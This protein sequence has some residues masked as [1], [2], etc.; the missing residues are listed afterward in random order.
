MIYRILLILILFASTT[1]AN[2][3]F[4][5]VKAG[6][7]LS[8]M[9]DEGGDEDLN[10]DFDENYLF[11]PGFH[12][13]FLLEMNYNDFTSFEADLLFS[14]KG[15]RVKNE[16][17]NQ[18]I[19]NRFITY[20]I[21]I[22]ILAKF[23]K[24]LDLIDLFVGIGPYLGFTFLGTYEEEISDTE[25]FNESNTNKLE[26]GGKDGDDIKPFDFGLIANTGIGFKNF[27]FII[28]YELGV[29][30]LSPISTSDF[31]KK[32]RVIGFSLAYK[33]ANLKK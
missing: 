33:F 1:F 28:S 20:N 10:I 11:I 6:I 15:Y 29:A 12:A 26:L 9:I 7:N 5:G 32:N 31:K 2:D 30:N 23:N 27:A 21:E 8:N 22:P 24:Q 17:I 3:L 13:G 18:T 14:T 4:F 19:T 25:N 16:Q